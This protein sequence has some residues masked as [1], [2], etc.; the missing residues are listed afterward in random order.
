MTNEAIYTED[1]DEIYHKT[2]RGYKKEDQN[3]SE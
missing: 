2:E 3:L 1:T